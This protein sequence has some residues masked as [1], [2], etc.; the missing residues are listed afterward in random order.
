M[1]YKILFIDDDEIVLES[2]MARYRKEYKVLIANT[3]DK[4][5]QFVYSTD[6]FSVII[7]DMKM[8]GMSGIELLSRIKNLSPFSARIMLT[9]YTQ[10]DI[11]IDAVN[12]GEI[13]R[14]LSKPCSAEIMD[15]AIRDGIIIYKSITKDKKIIQDLLKGSIKVLI[16]SV[17]ISNPRS[18][19]RSIRIRNISRRIAQDIKMNSSVD[20]EIAAMIC[21]IGYIGIDKNIIDKFENG[22]QLSSEEDKVFHQYPLIGASLIKNIPKMDNVSRIIEYHLCKYEDYM[23]VESSILSIAIRFEEL[24][25]REMSIDSII[26]KMIEFSDLFEENSFRSFLKIYSQ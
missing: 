2:Y 5:L 16:D 3:P 24:C 6:D 18:Y 19:E 7:S 14:F 1:K 12:K 21:L 17:R 9:G 25:S 10:A 22:V 15:K 4:A 26:D 11:A 8:I 20:I 13:F 23:P